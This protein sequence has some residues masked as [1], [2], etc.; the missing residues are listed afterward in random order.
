MPKNINIIKLE[1]II[2][3]NIIIKIY[4]YFKLNNNNILYINLYYLNYYNNKL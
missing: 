4:F 3:F 1:I 2:T